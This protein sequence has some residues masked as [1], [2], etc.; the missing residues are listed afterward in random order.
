MKFSKLCNYVIEEGR[1]ASTF[2]KTAQE[3]IDFESPT[4]KLS[5]TQIAVAKI[6]DENPGLGLMDIS[7]KINKIPQM[8]RQYLLQLTAKGLIAPTAEKSATATAIP[9]KQPGDASAKPTATKAEVKAEVKPEVKAPAVDDTM[10][11]ILA[12]LS[13]ED[14]AALMTK[15]GITEPK[16]AEAK[17]AEAQPTNDEETTEPVEDEEISLR[18][19]VNSKVFEDAVYDAVHRAGPQGATASEITR[20]ILRSRSV[21]KIKYDELDSTKLLLDVKKIAKELKQQGI[22]K[23]NVHNDPVTYSIAK[24]RDEGEDP[25]LEAGADVE[26]GDVWGEDESAKA[27]F[28][29]FRRSQQLGRGYEYED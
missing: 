5:P 29:D 16:P 28:D 6:I 9:I 10:K 8:T 12:K 19:K 21:L 23:I 1:Q 17:P 26:P 22:F 18:K 13:P 14:R 24:T 7:K 15:M 27:A 25:E 11:A 2:Y 20:D 4:L 3:N